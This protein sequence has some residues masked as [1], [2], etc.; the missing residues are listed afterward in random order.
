MIQVRLKDAV[1]L[2]N[3]IKPGIWYFADESPIIYDPQTFAPIKYYIILCDDGKYRKIDIDF[4][5]FITIDEWR[6][7]RL[8]SL[9]YD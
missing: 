8:E 5:K 4:D 1:F 6:E 2:S 3:F 7:N 9:L